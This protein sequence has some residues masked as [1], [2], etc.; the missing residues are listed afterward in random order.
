MD[1]STTNTPTNCKNCNTHHSQKYCP[2]CGHPAQ[3][4]RID[5][6][7]V[8]HE[9]EHLFHIERGMLFTVKALIINPGQVI[10]EYLTEN[11][12]KLMKPIFFIIVTSL[13]YSIISH[14]F[15]IEEIA[16]QN[17][18]TKQTAT[19]AIFQWVQAHYGYAN[20]IM[21]V[22]IALWIKLIFR[23]YGYNFFEILVL[24]CYTMGMGMLI[25]ALFALFQ[26]LL[27]IEL[28]QV[29]SIVA[30]VYCARVIAQF[31]DK[32]NLMNY[33][34]ALL[35]YILGMVT[36]YVLVLILGNVIDM[37]QF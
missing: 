14:Y 9:L 33:L 7:Y 16:A 37:I 12:S 13:V 36:F 29:G 31:F 2:N 1:P 6:G 21:G 17:G 24:L 30:F 15:H 34:K 5:G 8:A 18:G 35:A 22:F 20:I 19:L 4:K 3:L 26:G 27:K 32:K 23:T 25:F 10:R 28:M 11:R